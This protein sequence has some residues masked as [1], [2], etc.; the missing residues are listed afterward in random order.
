MA[1]VLH[2]MTMDLPD[3]SAAHIHTGMAGMNGGVAI[4][5]EQ[6]IDDMNHWWVAEA[7]TQE[8]YDDLM[9][10]GLYI[11]VH[12]ATNPSGELRGQLLPDNITVIWSPLSGDNEV[13]AVMTSASG[14]AALTINTDT[15]AMVLHAMTMDL[16]DASAA[17]IHTGMAGMNG[18]VAIGLEQDIDDMNHWWVAEAFTQ[19]QYDDLMAGGL[20]INVH[21]A[22][23]PSGE[24]RGQLLL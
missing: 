18:G 12:S 19:E 13:P 23:N 4:G 2:A 17:H 14:R 10:G 7:F 20:Y 11:N 21:S 6:D 22:T 8:Q 5:L 9:A 15:M 24:L 16:P 1:M 3:A